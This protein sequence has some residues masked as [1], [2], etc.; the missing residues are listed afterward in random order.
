M[1]YASKLSKEEARLDWS[2]PA[3]ELARRVRAYNPAPVAW[4]ELDGE[5]IRLW[6][7][8]ARPAT[9]PAAAG[10][11]LAAD[12]AGLHIACAE[13]VLLVSELQRPGGKALPAAALAQTWPLLGK[14]FS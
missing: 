12:E 6:N 9:A 2:R 5:R 4:S 7:A 11:V 8:R 14:R 3:E 1:T 10:T 13:G